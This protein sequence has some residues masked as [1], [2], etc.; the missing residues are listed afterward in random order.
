[1]DQGV[2]R[3]VLSKMFAEQ[4]VDLS[5]EPPS[6][7]AAVGDGS[8]GMGKNSAG[9]TLEPEEGGYERIS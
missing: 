2:P 4:S 1:M 6:D 3:E 7:D 9:N 5:P 8:P